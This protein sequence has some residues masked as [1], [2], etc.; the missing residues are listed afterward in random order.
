MKKVS[1]IVPVYGAEKY[2]KK[3]LESLVNQT[4]KDIE[5]IV[6]NDGTKDNSQAIIDEFKERYPEKII[7]IIKENEGQA[8]ARNIGTAIAKSE[9]IMYVDSD[10]W[11][12]HTMS[13][14]MYNNAKEK[15]ADIVVCDHYQVRNDNLIYISGID[16]DSSESIDRSFLVTASSI[17]CGKLF[18]RKYLERSK[19]KFL[20][21]HIYEDIAT[22]PAHVIFTSSISHIE[23][24]L[25]YYL[26]REGSTMNQI[27]YNKKL[28]DIFDSMDNILVL[29]K[30]Y[31]KYNMYKEELEYLY[32]IHLLHEATLRFIKFDNYKDNV[33]KIIRIMKKEFPKWIDNKYYKKKSIKYKI[34]CR[35]IMMNQIKLVIFFINCK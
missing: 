21:R 4:L 12:D 19:L 20:E 3:C 16:K 31:N 7:S 34:I 15:K 24:P 22:V 6:I 17:T 27:T 9:Y 8:I 2:I 1:I 35:L 30:K 10:D 23:E 32:I 29:F 33:D 5:I 25:Y 18:R 26:I 13:E 11:I 28:E 14:K